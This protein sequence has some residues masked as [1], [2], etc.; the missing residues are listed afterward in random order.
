MRVAIVSQYCSDSKKIQQWEFF[1]VTTYNFL[2]SW[3]ISFSHYCP[4]Y[5]LTNVLILN[6]ANIRGSK[7]N[8][9]VLKPYFIKPTLVEILCT[10][11][12][13]LINFLIFNY[14]LK[15]I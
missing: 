3:F 2:L 9:K 7:I 13:N 15:F 14:I 11:H 6:N 12:Y 5:Y 10:G 4:F 8:D 1:L